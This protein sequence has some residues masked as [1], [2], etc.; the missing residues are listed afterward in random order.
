MQQQLVNPQ[1]FIISILNNDV[2]NV[3]RMLNINPSL[4]NSRIRVNGGNKVLIPILITSNE[5]IVKL[6]IENGA[7]VN[8]QDH[9][10]WTALHKSVVNN[11][12]KIVMILLKNGANVNALLRI[13]NETP[14]HK[15][16]QWNCEKIARILIENG[17]DIDAQDSLGSTPLYLASMGKHPKIVALL[18][19]RGAN[20]QIKNKRGENP[21]DAAE[22]EEV[23][24]VFQQQQKRLL[25]ARDRFMEGGTLNQ[26]SNKTS[27]GRTILPENRISYFPTMR[28]EVSGGGRSIRFSQQKPKIKRKKQKPKT[29]QQLQKQQELKSTLEYLKRDATFEPWTEL[30]ELMGPAAAG[31]GKGVQQQKKQR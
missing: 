23:R 24:K 8:A 25:T 7:D 21:S 14:L 26:Y 29:K 17:A 6:L 15:A 28:E 10:G 22:S 11:H 30:M 31:G 1:N 18:L 12:E 3:R 2:E 9:L 19:R 5:K 16:I 4:A 27:T 13:T 20:D